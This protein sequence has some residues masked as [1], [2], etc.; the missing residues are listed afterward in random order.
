M[1]MFDEKTGKPMMVSQV[2]MLSF[3]A[4][5]TDEFEVPEASKRSRARI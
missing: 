5:K 3:A 4:L 2:T 1:I